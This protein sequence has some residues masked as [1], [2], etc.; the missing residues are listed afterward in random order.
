MEW[1]GNGMEWSGLEKAK[2]K[3]VKNGRMNGL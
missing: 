1:T 3:K 2:R